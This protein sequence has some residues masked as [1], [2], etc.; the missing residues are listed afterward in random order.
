MINITA[1]IE[2]EYIGLP[3]DEHKGTTHNNV[4]L[5]LK[6]W[7]KISRRDDGTID[8]VR[9]FNGAARDLCMRVENRRHLA[10]TFIG[11]DTANCVDTFIFKLA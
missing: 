7:K 9:M 2:I 6:K 10:W 8:T 1:E 3:T 5:A 4:I 11:V